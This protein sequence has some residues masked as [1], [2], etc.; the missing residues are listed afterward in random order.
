MP[1]HLTFGWP[2]KQNK[3]AKN[4]WGKFQL[5]HYVHCVI[6]D[7]PQLMLTAGP[8]MI[9]AA[10]QQPGY[11]G[12]PMYAGAAGAYGPGQMPGYGMWA[13]CT[14]TLTHFK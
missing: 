5:V 7:E 9:P 4:M 14:D 8:G 6:L 12:A 2:F 3:F 10:P 13:T 11:G 1:N